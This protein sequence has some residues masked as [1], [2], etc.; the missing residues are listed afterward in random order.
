MIEALKVMKYRISSGLIVFCWSLGLLSS[1]KIVDAQPAKQS[2][3]LR[4]TI[5][6]PGTQLAW[7]ED[8]NARSEYS[9]GF[10]LGPGQREGDIELTQF[11]TDGVKLHIAASNKELDLSYPASGP[12]TVPQPNDK[13]NPCFVHLEKVA[14]DQVL[15]VYQKLAGRTLLRSSRIPRAELTIAPTN[16]PSK[17]ALLRGLETALAEQGVMIQ[18]HRDK[19]ALVATRAA[20][21][22]KVKPEL[23]D[24]IAALGSEDSA[25]NQS[26]E[27]GPAEFAP[28]MIN[29]PGTD[30][31]QVLRVYEE[32]LGR[33]IVRRSTIPISVF[34]LRT[35]TALTRTEAHYAFA[36]TLALNDI[37][38]LPAGDKF[39]LMFMTWDRQEISNMLARI[40]PRAVTTNSPSSTNSPITAGSLQFPGTRLDDLARI[41]EHLLGQ[42]V[43]IAASNPVPVLF[44][45]NQSALSKEEALYGIELLFGVNGLAVVPQDNG[46]GV[47]IVPAA[48]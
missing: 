15:A 1:E 33:T 37:S 11:H 46:Q 9:R 24:T 32:L 47:K 16:T 20:D 41:Y 35:E 38:V 6:W 39:L 4:G 40:K 28:G 44:L 22:E 36:A 31:N 34:S 29:F 18:P 26:H 7:I 45:H 3:V 48:R 14:V 19:F 43:E 8:T 12:D 2:F 21:F 30:I 23:W 27:T 42:R 10:L 25:S 17:F 13:Q 5:S